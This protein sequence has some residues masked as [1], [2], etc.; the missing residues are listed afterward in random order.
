MPVQLNSIFVCKCNFWCKKRLGSLILLKTQNLPP[1][2]NSLGKRLIIGHN[3]N[4]S[5]LVSIQFILK[6][7]WI[8]CGPICG[9]VCM[10]APIG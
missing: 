9:G 10:Q 8:A 6:G 1:Q 4:E 3:V 7:I 2:K 5:S